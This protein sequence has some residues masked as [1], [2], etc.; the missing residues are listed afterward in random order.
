[1]HLSPTAELPRYVNPE[2]GANSSAV[3]SGAM[4]CEWLRYGIRSVPCC[5]QKYRDFSKVPRLPEYQALHR[6]PTLSSFGKCPW[7]KIDSCRS[8]HEYLSQ[9]HELC[10]QAKDFCLQISSSYWWLLFR[11][12]SKNNLASHQVCRR[13]SEIPQDDQRVALG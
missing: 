13:H 12:N 2:R 5:R 6:A 8:R 7:Q 4:R 10:H 1:M 3:G 11:H 9:E